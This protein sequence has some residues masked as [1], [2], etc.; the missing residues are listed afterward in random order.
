MNNTIA[1]TFDAIHRGML[2]ELKSKYG[3]ESRTYSK[4]HIQIESA[5]T[6]SASNMF[7]SAHVVNNALYDDYSAVPNRGQNHRLLMKYVRK[8]RLS[9][10]AANNRGTM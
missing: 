10:R 2:V 5:M 4:N 8:T 3:K 9:V 7:M 1:C 6:D